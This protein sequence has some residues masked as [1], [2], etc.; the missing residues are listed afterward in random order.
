MNCSQILLPNII[1]KKEN[2]DANKNMD[3]TAEKK[4]Y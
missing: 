3:N 1:F 4:N 2:F